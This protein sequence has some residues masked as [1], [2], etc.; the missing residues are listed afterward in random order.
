MLTEHVLIRRKEN[1]LV[2][3]LRLC[4]ILQVEV[5]KRV[6][7]SSDKVREEVLLRKRIFHS[8]LSP[9]K[10]SGQWWTLIL[11]SRVFPHLRFLMESFFEDVPERK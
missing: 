11:I 9:R 3:L 7:N 10:L 4:D 5:C 8:T 1:D 2:I 6:L